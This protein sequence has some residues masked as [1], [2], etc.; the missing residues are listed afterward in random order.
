MNNQKDLNRTQADINENVI[1]ILADTFH[2]IIHLTNR[3]NKLEISISELSRLA[4]T[5]SQTVSN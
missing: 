1:A 5:E 3:I 2:E 4:K